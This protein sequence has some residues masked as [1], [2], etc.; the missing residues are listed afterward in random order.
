MLHWSISAT[1]RQRISGFSGSGKALMGF[2]RFSKENSVVR[3]LVYG[4]KLSLYY[5]GF[6]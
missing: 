2:F 5:M 4:N 6:I 1:A 3:R